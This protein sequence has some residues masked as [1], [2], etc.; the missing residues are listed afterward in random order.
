[1]ESRGFREGTYL[2][3]SKDH[4][5]TAIPLIR[6][7]FEGMTPPSPLNSFDAPKNRL[8][9]WSQTPPKIDV[10]QTK[11]DMRMKLN[12]L[13]G[14]PNPRKLEDVWPEATILN[15]TLEGEL[16]LLNE[17]LRQQWKV[18]R[19]MSM[20]DMKGVDI[21][22]CLEDSNITDYMRKHG[23][24]AEDIISKTEIETI[25]PV[26]VAFFNDVKEM[27]TMFS[28]LGYLEKFSIRSKQFKTTF[29]L[30]LNSQELYKDFIATVRSGI[31]TVILTDPVKQ[32]FCNKAIAAVGEHKG[33][34]WRINSIIKTAGVCECIAH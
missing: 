11:L 32:D 9:I 34:A 5:R 17:T 21:D 28:N 13:L 29:V 4:D 30:V 15:G 7:L 18:L 20:I 19:F 2:I 22:E 26:V 23:L 14:Q 12:E 10:P 31:D 3:Y 8:M 27:A 24:K 16:G 25:R 1:M 33:K 6:S